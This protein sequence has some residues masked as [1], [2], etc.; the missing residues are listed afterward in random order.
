MTKIY[1]QEEIDDL[2]SLEPAEYMQKYPELSFEAVGRKRQRLL[3][4]Q[5]QTTPPPLP[6]ELTPEEQK[7]RVW[8]FIWK[9]RKAGTS[10]E[11]I[12]DILHI[13]N[14]E[15]RA[16][17]ELLKGEAKTITVNRYGEVA[18]PTSGANPENPILQ[19]PDPGKV[20][21]FG[22]IGDTHLV[23]IDDRLDSLNTY[24]DTIKNQGIE[25]VLHAGD[26]F[27]GMNVYKGHNNNIRFNGF[28][29]HMEYGVN[30]DP[31]R[32]GV[33]TI[34]IGGNHDESFLKLAG[35][36]PVAHFCRLRDD[37]EYL[38]MYDGSVDIGGV[39]V[40]LHHGHG[41]SY[42]QSYQLQK[43]V[44]KIPVKERP[45]IF[46]CGHWHHAVA[47]LG[48]QGID[49]L[50]VGCFQGRTGLGTR[51]GG[52]PTIGGWI[53]EVEHDKERLIRTK[54]EFLHLD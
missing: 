50:S 21:R 28:D 2:L 34:F 6:V 37:A 48:Y 18:I 51:L 39:V 22:I 3:H 16:T 15:V 13:P 7:K 45:H 20:F 49:S 44:E 11:Q 38:G 36:D 17:I 31:Y 23:S 25:L 33:K 35:I 52:Y 40:G 41:Y 5:T 10:V 12:A 26:L 1:S 27:D 24:Y 8:E 47:M 32:T 19:L 46:A 54:L 29:R 9:A 43:Y 42:A 53:V 30:E 14:H 4:S